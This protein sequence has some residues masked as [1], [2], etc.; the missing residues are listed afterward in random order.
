VQDCNDSG[1]ISLPKKY[2]SVLLK[3]NCVAGLL[4]L[5]PQLCFYPDVSTMGRLNKIPL[6]ISGILFFVA[7]FIV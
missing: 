1:R 2:S 7:R 3:G 6:A 5:R 4:Q